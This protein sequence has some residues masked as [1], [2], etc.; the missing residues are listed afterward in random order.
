[1]DY[2]RCIDVCIDISMLPEACYVPKHARVNN[3]RILMIGLH[4][5]A[6]NLGPIYE[7]KILDFLD[8]WAVVKLLSLDRQLAFTSML[9]RD[10]YTNKQKT[11]N[12]PS[13]KS[14]LRS[15]HDRLAS[16]HVIR[17]S[18]GINSGLRITTTARSPRC[19][20]DRS[21]TGLWWFAID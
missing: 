8:S 4:R 6:T 15:H 14:D 16:S 2:D 9:G 1:M 5:I 21:P 12:W 7:L 10:W 18:I 13:N 11:Y 19:T 17:K 20:C 3:H